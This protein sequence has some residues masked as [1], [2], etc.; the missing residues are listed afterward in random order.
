MSVVNFLAGSKLKNGTNTVNNKRPRQQM[1]KQTTTTTTTTTTHR[2]FHWSTRAC[3]QT[4]DDDATKMNKESIVSTTPTRRLVLWGEMTPET[5]KLARSIMSHRTNSDSGIDGDN[6]DDY[7][8]GDCNDDIYDKND[9]KKAKEGSGNQQIPLPIPIQMHPRVAISRAITL[10]ES[11]HPFKRKQGDLLLTYLLSLSS[12]SSSSSSSSVNSTRQQNNE[13]TCTTDNSTA[14]AATTTTTTTTTTT[15]RLSTFPTETLRV[16]FAGPPGAGKSSL[17]EVFCTKL[18]REDPQLKLAVVCID[19]SSTVSGG[20]ILGDKTR[21]T[22]LSRQADGRALV[23]PSSNSG[24]LGGLAAYTDDVVRLLGCAGYP[25]VFV[26]TVGLGQSEIEVSQSV[27]VLVLLIPPSG[28]DELQGVK[29]GIV[30]IADVLAVTKTDGDLEAAANQTA[31]DYKG[32][33]RVLHQSHTSTGSNDDKW[34]PPVVSTS[35]VTERGLD[36]LWQTILRYQQHLLQTGNW[37][38]QR[39]KQ[40]KYWM[41]KQFSRMMQAK[42]QEDTGLREKANQLERKMLDG[43]LTPRVSAQILMDELLESAK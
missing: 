22:Q 25:L 43:L 6:D 5:R 24:I 40:A 35:S 41:W 31:A 8:D 17:M 7:N 27:D 38:D 30:E 21:M 28:G 4:A 12:S 9:D 1:H 34:M 42:M 18:L 10:M 26:E 2:S 13:T 14:T 32:A 39:R 33:L 16:G 3:S 23:R 15:A 37:E 19:P 20:S 11:K 29:K 36:D